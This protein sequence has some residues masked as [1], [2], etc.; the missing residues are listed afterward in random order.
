M[1]QTKKEVAQRFDF[2][3]LII[4]INWDEKKEELELVAPSDFTLENLKSIFKERLAKRSVPLSAVQEAKMEAAF[5]G[6]MRQI[7]SLSQGLSQERAKEVIKLIRDSKLKV[8][9][10]IQ[11][12]QIRVSGKNKDDLQQVMALVRG[13]GFDFPLQFEN[14][15]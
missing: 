12:E 8:S 2:K 11:G 15:R 1:E 9:T 3:G 4:E 14:Y 6:T 10:Q 7:L 5:S 13:Q